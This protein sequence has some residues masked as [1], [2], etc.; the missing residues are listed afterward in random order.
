MSPK[1]QTQLP[2]YT[3]LPLSK[4]ELLLGMLASAVVLATPQS[5][6]LAASHIRSVK[7]ALANGGELEVHKEAVFLLSRGRRRPLRKGVFSLA[8]GGRIELQD[9]QIISAA[10]GS[11]D[12]FVKVVWIEFKDPSSGPPVAVAADRLKA[13]KATAKWQISQ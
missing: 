9:G 3:Q 5:R 12:P 7:L 10:M 6:L 11:G 13:A 8:S 1:S 4:R 2:N